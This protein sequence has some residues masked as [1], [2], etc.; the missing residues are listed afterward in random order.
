MA[1]ALIAERLVLPMERYTGYSSV[2]FER[3]GDVLRVT[4]ANPR[5]KLN[6]VD[7]EMH[8]ELV[9]L[10]EEL[11][12][13]QAARAVVLTGSGR[14]FS[15]GGD[16]NWMQSVTADG[17]YEMRREGK[18]IVWNLLD[19]EVPVVAAVNGPAVGLGATL[20]LLCDV[21]FMADTAIV[22]DP[23]VQVGIVAGDG[24]AVAWPLAVGPVLAKRY[25]LT[26]D[27]LT[28]ADAERLGLVARAVPGDELQSEALA[29][30]ERLAS[31]APL[32]VRYTKAA[33][34]QLVKQAMATAFDYSTALEVLTFASADHKEAL[35]A[36]SAKEAPR[37]EGR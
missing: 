24:G 11:K 9:R 35:R 16:F 27:P 3:R 26:G 1:G 8:A 22:S 36:L 30:A 21:V 31:G 23:H 12:T 19:V 6:A 13:E 29:F 10:F 7:G 17:F 28:A 37:F 32:A 20:A 34:N 5:N 33:V 14:A 4:L 2:E 15:A 25:L 18:Q